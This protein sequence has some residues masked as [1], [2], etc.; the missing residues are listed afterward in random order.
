MDALRISPAMD[1][2]TATVDQIKRLI[3]SATHQP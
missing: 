1:T 2:T 3:G